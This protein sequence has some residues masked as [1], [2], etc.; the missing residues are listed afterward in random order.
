MIFRSAF[1]CIEL[2]KEGHVRV[3]AGGLVWK[4]R[5]V[6]TDGSSRTSNYFLQAV[7]SP[8]VM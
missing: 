3:V 6:Q 2:L 4:G 8:D 7:K 1:K 5:A